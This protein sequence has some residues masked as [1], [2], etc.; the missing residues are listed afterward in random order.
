M[1]LDAKIETRKRELMIAWGYTR[2][3][4]T[5][6]LVGYCRVINMSTEH[7]LLDAVSESSS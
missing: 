3:L 2:K 7:T 5:S 4:E 6:T 1:F